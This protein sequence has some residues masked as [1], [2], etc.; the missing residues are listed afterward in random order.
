LT[1][2]WDLDNDGIFETPGQS[3]IFDAALL[4]APAT[5]IVNVQVTDDGGLTAEDSATIN[6][7]YN[8]TGFFPPVVNPPA[9]NMSKAGSAISLKFS[10]GGDKGLDIFALGYPQSVQIA[11]DTGAIL[12]IPEQTVNPGGSSLT[13]NPLTNQYT[14]P[15]KT[16]KGWAGTCRQ[17]TVKLIDGTV[18]IAN[19][20]FK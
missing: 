12:G 5:F 16:I 11:C 7:I 14:Y 20:Q 19:F 8:F 1:Y 2:S 15:W 3:A 17:L 9:I 4:T 18:Q 10:L 6:V 13:Y